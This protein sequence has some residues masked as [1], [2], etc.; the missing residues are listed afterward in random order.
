MKQVDKDSSEKGMV[1]LSSPSARL[2]APP[3]EVK[4]N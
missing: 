2:K 3:Q 4:G 1:I